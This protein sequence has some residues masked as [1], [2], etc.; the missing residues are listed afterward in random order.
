MDSATVG[1]GLCDGAIPFFG[2][3]SLTALKKKGGGV[4]PVAAGSLLR[5]CVGAL[6]AKR[7]V[8]DIKRLVGHGQFGVDVADGT[9]CAAIA[10][11]EWA[12]AQLDVDGVA[13]QAD[14]ENAFNMISRARL[15]KLI[16]NKA[17]FLAPYVL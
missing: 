11:E 5:R 7:H 3:A 4:R 10:F 8:H 6:L 17:P 16:L 13:V 14:F 15:R 2:G 12:T 1:N 9:L